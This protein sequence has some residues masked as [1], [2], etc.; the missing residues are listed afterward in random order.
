[1]GQGSYG[2]GLSIGYHIVSGVLGGSITA[3]SA[4]GQKLER[5]RRNSS[6]ME[7][8]LLQM[9]NS[10]I[11]PEAC[12]AAEQGRFSLVMFGAVLCLGETKRK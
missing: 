4:P 9:R 6:A 7:N 1:M 3:H 8:S 12:I 5:W 10:A 2:L 11:F